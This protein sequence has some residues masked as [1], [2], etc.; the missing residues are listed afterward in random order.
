MT[1]KSSNVPILAPVMVIVAQGT[2]KTISF[3]DEYM[4]EAVSLLISNLD[5]TNV[6]TYQI[7]G[8]AMPTLTLSTS[9]FRS[10]DDTKIRLIT[11]TAGAAG[12]VQV[13]AQVQSL[14]RN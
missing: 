12:A 9:S 5:A 8:P 11:V 3:P 4:G 10:F 13:Q 7:G 1:E 14:L 6:A 2:S